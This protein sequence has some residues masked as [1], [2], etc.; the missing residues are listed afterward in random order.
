MTLVE[1][2]KIMIAIE[3]IQNDLNYLATESNI[4]DKYA[5]NLLYNVNVQA[6][7][8]ELLLKDI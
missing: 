8:L 5:L 2:T 6:T 4:K 1:K 3:N 7:Q